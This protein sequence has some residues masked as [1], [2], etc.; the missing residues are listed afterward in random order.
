MKIHE[1]V[2]KVSME[3]FLERT[4]GKKVILLYP[5]TNYRTLFLSHFIE[6][7]NPKLL[8]Y[9]ISD[10]QTTL[11]AWLAGMVDEFNQVIGEFGSNI[12][13]VLENGNPKALAEALAADL[14]AYR[15]DGCILYVD[16]LDRIPFD[17]DFAQF[18][19][20][21][22]A[23]IPSHVQIAFN[24]RLLT[25]QPWYDMVAHGEAVVLGTEYRKDDVMFTVQETPRPQLEVY[26]LGRG[27][28]VVNGQH[29]SNWDGALPR[30]LFFFFMDRNLVT[31]KQ[32]FETFWP[33]L[34]VK[35]ATNVFHVTKR[36]ITERISLKVDL[37]NSYEL[38]QYNGGFYLP[39]EKVVRHYDVGDFQ[40]AI[41]RSMVTTDER[42]EERLLVSAVES[43]KAPFLQDTD[44]P[45]MKE[46]RENL[47]LMHAQA[48]IGLGRINRRRGEDKNALDYFTRSLKETP[49][50]ED[51]HR[52]VMNIYL[53]MGMA[54]DA[55]EQ[56]NRLVEILHKEL[57]I[58][59]SRESQD[60]NKLIEASI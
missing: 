37:E 49:Q 39:S 25:Y 26:A 12:R 28:A 38:T 1:L 2:T 3:T 43:Y 55:R 27:Y 58:G 13:S 60:L 16:E 20:T 50:R 24:S 4:A 7:D 11:A 10:G 31:R 23:S 35:E 36:K 5:W 40:A 47:R 14:G 56:Y 32:I 41:E 30:N 6:E 33:E 17:A 57:N 51:I 48:L 29:I 15:S 53:R 54:S 21:L 42:E 19:K 18:A 52:E 9:R 45:W 59:P 46:R 8:Y 22:I 34:P 44:M